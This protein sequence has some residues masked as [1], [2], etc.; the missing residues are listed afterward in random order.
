MERRVGLARRIHVVGTSG[1]GKTTFAKRLAKQM[2]ISHVELDSLFWGPGW[3]ETPDD[4]FRR[5]VRA[6]VGGSQ[7]VIDGNY[8]RVRDLIWRRAEM[9]IWL[10]Y[11]LCVIV[12]RVVRRT[13]RRSLTREELWNG[14]RESLKTSL[15]SRES[16]VLWSLRT[17]RRRKR[18]YAGMAK[19]PENEH[20]RVLR[21]RTVRQARKLLED[22]TR[23]LRVVKG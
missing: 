19:Q 17:Y 20:L 12:F 7:W 9:V 21:M 1:S 14:N 23:Y 18:E 15:F 10:D 11:R 13:L 22:P 8:S 2:E 3:S 5:E 4:E 16:I 6:V